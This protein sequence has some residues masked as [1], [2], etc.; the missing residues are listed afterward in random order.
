MN[1]KKLN[2]AAMLTLLVGIAMAAIPGHAAASGFTLASMKGNY[3]FRAAGFTTDD[4]GD[5]GAIN[6]VGI[7]GLNGA[8]GITSVDIQ[9][10][11]G[12]DSSAD[13]FDCPGISLAPTSSYSV[14][15]DGTG[16]F[17]I[18]FPPTDLCLPSD[19]LSFTFALS[20]TSGAVGQLNSSTFITSNL[21]PGN[22]DGCIVTN[23]V[24]LAYPASG[25]E[26]LT[27]MVLDGE[28]SSQ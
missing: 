26:C 1:L 12:D 19:T 11:G 6:I 24:Y 28:I 2:T 9:V 25:P 17:N 14:N 27:A 10:S 21:F 15:P 20:R 18:V 7:M 16:S 8:G 3:I 22:E 13:R 23:E 5:Q 4:G